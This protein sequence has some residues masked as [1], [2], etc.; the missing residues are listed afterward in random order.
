M[1]PADTLEKACTSDSTT[2][3]D[4][5]GFKGAK[6]EDSQFWHLLWGLAKHLARCVGPAGSTMRIKPVPFRIPMAH[7]NTWGQQLMVHRRGLS[8]ISH[9]GTSTLESVDTLN[10]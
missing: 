9:S 6:L 1:S 10:P 7:P 2:G 5:P 3:V 8:R 4:I